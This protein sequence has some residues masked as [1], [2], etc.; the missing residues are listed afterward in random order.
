MK[1]ELFAQAVEELAKAPKRKFK[2]SY[3]LILNLK[4]LNL[5]K[6]ENHVEFWMEL[7]Q[8][9]GKPT[10]IG[11]LVGPELAEQAKASCDFVIVHSEFPK[12]AADKRAVKKIAGECD[13]FIA[14]ANLMGDV[15]KTF[16]RIFGPR[17]R[18]PNPKAGC[19]VPPN[20]NLKVLVDK[21]RKTVR[22][23]AKVQPSIKLLIGKEGMPTEQVVENMQAVYNS[24]VQHLPQE[25]GN[26]RSVLLKLTMSAPIKI[27]DKGIEVKEKKAPA[28]PKKPAK[29][30]AA[31]KKE[32]PVEEPKEEVKEAPE[33]KAEEASEEGAQ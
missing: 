9:K 16:G 11:A 17:G 19:V 4:G 3:E 15:A 25:T 6:P 26:M 7:P 30:K 18:M 31:P 2:Q 28:E 1:K 14:Q 29:K 20:A 5:K 23:S 24:L 27:T 12:Y 8:D 13:Y 22:I 33:E 10:K 21:L 32:T